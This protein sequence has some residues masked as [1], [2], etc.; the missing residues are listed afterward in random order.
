M[1]SIERAKLAV[2]LNPE[3]ADRSLCTVSEQDKKGEVPIHTDVTLTLH[4]LAV[5]PDVTGQPAGQAP[6]AIR[7][8]GGSVGFVGGGVP[9]DQAACSIT[10]QSRVGNVEPGTRIVLDYYCPLT[11]EEV[12]ESAESLATDTDKPG[13]THA[14]GACQVTSDVDGVCDVTY[15]PP[16]GFTCAG[17]I[18]VTVVNDGQTVTFPARMSPAASVSPEGRS[19]LNR[20]ETAAP[21]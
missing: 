4:C 10:T 8:A 14:L 15:Y 9:Y 1:R 3:P 13:E 18:F 16:E 6:T 11:L 12:Q 17:Q 19:N 5:I 7:G 21:C 2:V 20:V